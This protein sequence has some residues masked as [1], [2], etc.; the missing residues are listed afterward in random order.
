MNAEI[1]N[2]HYCVHYMDTGNSQTKVRVRSRLS[3]STKV[4]SLASLGSP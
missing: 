4:A 1:E 2:A 3:K